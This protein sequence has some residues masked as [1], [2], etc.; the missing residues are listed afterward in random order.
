M[1]TEDDQ[2]LMSLMSRFVGELLYRMSE[3]E[4]ERQ[5]DSAPAPG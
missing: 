5:P 3:K 1:F 4:I 2:T